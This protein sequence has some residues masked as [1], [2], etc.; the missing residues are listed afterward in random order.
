ML[1]QLVFA[2]IILMFVQLI[3]SCGDE[4]QILIA[5]GIDEKL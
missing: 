4:F 3:K 5:E 2:Q 1:C